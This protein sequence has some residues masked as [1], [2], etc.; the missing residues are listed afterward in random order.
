MAA[1]DDRRAVVLVCRGSGDAEPRVGSQCCG[2]TVA[3][4]FRCADAAPADE[5]LDELRQVAAE[6]DA[7]QTVVVRGGVAALAEE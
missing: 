4:T 2:Y 1:A 5:V 7:V 6:L 3:A